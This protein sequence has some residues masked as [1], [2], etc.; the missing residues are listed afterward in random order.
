MAKVN[1]LSDPRLAPRRRK[2]KPAKPAPAQVVAEFVHL[3]VDETTSKQWRHWEWAEARIEE[4]GQ[5]DHPR[6]GAELIAS[7]AEPRRYLILVWIDSG[8]ETLLEVLLCLSPA[9]LTDEPPPRV[10]IWKR[11]T[12]WAGLAGPL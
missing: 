6:L 12:D 7:N 11:P 3:L 1:P 5:L 8:D 2:P 9:P 4:L 10:A